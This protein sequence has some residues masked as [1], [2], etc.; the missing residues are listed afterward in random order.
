MLEDMSTDRNTG[1]GMGHGRD[2]E[3][4]QVPA[5][6]VAVKIV[7]ETTHFMMRRHRNAS[8]RGERTTVPMMFS[9]PLINP[10]SGCVPQSPSYPGFFGFTV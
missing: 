4:Q 2:V 6:R 5:R 1:N 3:R 7:K 8:K 10:N 9:V